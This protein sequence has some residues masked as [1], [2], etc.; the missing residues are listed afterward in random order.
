MGRKGRVA[1]ALATALVAVGVA[2]FAINQLNPATHV[3]DSMEGADRQALGELSAL[4]RGEAETE[5]WEGFSVT[6]H[7]VFA[8]KSAWGG[9][10]LA[11]PG[12]DPSGIFARK[13]EMPEGAGLDV[14]SV[15]GLAP[16]VLQFLVPANFNSIG[17]TVG[18]LGSDVYFLRYGESSFSKACDSGHFATML[19]HEAFHYYAQNNW[20]GPSRFETE[21]LSSADLDLLEEQY[22]V[23]DE[24]A[25]ALA[26]ETAD[27]QALGA[28]CDHYLDVAARRMAVNPSYMRE[29]QAA[30]TIEG[31]ATYVGI[32][33][34]EMV[35]YDFKVMRMAQD[36]GEPVDL[37]FAALAGLMRDGTLDVSSIS[38]DWT[39][40]SGAL[41]CQVL[42]ALGAEGW[43]AKL[44]AQTA[45]AVFDSLISKE[46]TG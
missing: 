45:D 36:G 43:Q 15:A 17:E 2:S 34:S 19:A 11:N 31:T 18:V 14:Y 26:A 12:S 28:L 3:Y 7:P 44:N 38:T 5:L 35:G 46:I 27:A 42:D 23:L 20:S 25:D 41:L 10:F 4:A 21:G 30:E 13:V 29:E 24:M 6:A 1:C 22:G 33:A 39:Y 32:K 16:D 9:G 37:S 8:L 40:Q